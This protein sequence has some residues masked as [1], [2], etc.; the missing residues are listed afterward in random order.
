MS[1]GISRLVHMLALWRS[2]QRR[3]IVPVV[4]PDFIFEQGKSVLRKSETASDKG[5]QL[6]AFIA[7]KNITRT[8]TITGT[9]SPEGVERINSKLAQERADAIEK[10]YRAEMKKYDY[11]NMADEIKF[12][13]KPVVDDW[14]GFKNALASYTCR[15]PVFNEGW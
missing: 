12:I 1:G 10:F 8:V 11:Q 9:H 5:K 14:T 4:I 3:E 13:L 6:D 7:A 15:I 2:P